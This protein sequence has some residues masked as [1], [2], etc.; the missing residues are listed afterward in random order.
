MKHYESQSSIQ[1]SLVKINQEE[2]EIL[3]QLKGIDLEIQATSSRTSQRMSYFLKNA[4][5]KAVFIASIPFYWLV[6]FK[7]VIGSFNPGFFAFV[8]VCSMVLSRF[9]GNWGVLNSMMN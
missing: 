8:L 7:Y 9:G 3:E 6:L 1:E 5:K 2:Q 4:C